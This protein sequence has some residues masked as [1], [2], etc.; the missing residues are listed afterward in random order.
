MSTVLSGAAILAIVG[1]V[2]VLAAVIGVVAWLLTSS[3][4]S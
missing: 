4:R 2:V 3:R 1:A